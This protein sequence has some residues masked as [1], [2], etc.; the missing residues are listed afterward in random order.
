MTSVFEK[1]VSE[2]VKLIVGDCIDLQFIDEQTPELCLIAITQNGAA[3][4]FVKEQ[5]PE[6]C[7]AA[8]KQNKN[9]LQ[10]IRDQKNIKYV[11]DTLNLK[12][13]IE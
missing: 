10:C 6:L 4:Q 8:V 5:T 3:L 13:P 7:L 12:Y 1:N 9:A 11:C 2:D